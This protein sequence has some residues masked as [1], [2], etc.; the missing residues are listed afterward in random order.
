MKSRGDQTPQLKNGVVTRVGGGQDDANKL[1]ITPGVGPWTL[2]TNKMN[3]EDRDL[4]WHV[5]GGIKLSRMYT[6]I[7]QLQTS[8]ISKENFYRVNAHH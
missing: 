7:A 4:V 1:H 5:N 6:T 8:Y 3:L 2:P